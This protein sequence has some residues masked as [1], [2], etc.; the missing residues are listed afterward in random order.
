MPFDVLAEGL[1]VQSSRGDCP[2]VEPLNELVNA[3]V[4]ALLE[5]PPAH[6]DSLAE[7]VATNGASSAHCANRAAG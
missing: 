2:T 5:L 3:Y 1:L 7:L 4:V 6:V